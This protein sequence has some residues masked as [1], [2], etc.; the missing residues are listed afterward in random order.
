M[1]IFVGGIGA[2]I[3]ERMPLLSRLGVRALIGATLV[4]LMTG[5]VAGMFYMNDGG[6]L[7]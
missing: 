4:T 7:R 5:A 6:I 3:P 2:L 1:G